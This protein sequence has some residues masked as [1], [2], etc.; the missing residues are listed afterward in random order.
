[1][2]RRMVRALQRAF[3]EGN[4]GNQGCSC[5]NCRKEIFAERDEFRL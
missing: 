3:T 4:E 5:Q 2:M 1:M